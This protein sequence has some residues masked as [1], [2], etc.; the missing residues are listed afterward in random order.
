MCERCGSLGY[1]FDCPKWPRCGCP[2]GTTALNCPG[3]S[4]PCPDCSPAAAPGA[5]PQPAAASPSPGR[6]LDAP[7]KSPS[8]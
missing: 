8:T 6:R 7:V 5:A 2:D 1:V 4:V 3:K